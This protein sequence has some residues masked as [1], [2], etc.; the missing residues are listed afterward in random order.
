MNGQF[1]RR[2]T[3]VWIVA[4]ALVSAAIVLGTANDRA[5]AAH[6]NEGVGPRNWVRVPLIEGRPLSAFL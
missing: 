6:G 4:A 3:G 2:M 5:A 1:G